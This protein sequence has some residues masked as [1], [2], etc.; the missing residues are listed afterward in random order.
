MDKKVWRFLKYYGLFFL[1]FGIL[2]TLMMVTDIL[3]DWIAMIIYFIAIIGSIYVGSGLKDLYEEDP[4]M[5]LIVST[6]VAVLTVLSTIILFLIDIKDPM[7]IVMVIVMVMILLSPYINFFSDKHTLKKGIPEGEK[8]IEAK[9]VEVKPVR[10]PPTKP[11]KIEPVYDQKM[12]LFLKTSLNE[13]Y[14]KEILYTTN[15][16][17][18]RELTVKES[19][20]LLKLIH[21]TGDSIDELTELYENSAI[22]GDT[23]SDMGPYIVINN[24]HIFILEFDEEECIYFEPEDMKE[25]HVVVEVEGEEEDAFRL[26]IAEITLKDDSKVSVNCFSEGQ[27]DEAVELLKD[28]NPDIEVGEKI[29][30]EF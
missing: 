6:F 7:F 3:N 21:F 2:F 17:S 29:I 19:H 11:P 18:V 16:E 24:N 13:E 23:D 28:L 20:S 5:T 14:S 27:A 9:E 1:F 15:M 25:A 22:Y 4:R 26:G 8:E 12:T 30:T 10:V